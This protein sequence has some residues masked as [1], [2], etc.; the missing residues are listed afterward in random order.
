MDTNIPIPTIFLSVTFYMTPV[1]VTIQ[2]QPTYLINYPDPLI[3]LAPVTIRADPTPTASSCTGDKCRKH[4]CILFGCDGSYSLFSCNSSCG[5]Y[6]Y[7]SGCSIIGCIVNCLLRSCGGL[8]CLLPGSCGNIQGSNSSNSSNKYDSPAIVLVCTYL[9][10]S[11]STWYLA[12]FLTIIETNCVTS[13]ACNRQDIVVI[14]IPGS[15]QCSVDPNILKILSVKQAADQTIINREQIPLKTLIVIQTITII[16]TLTIIVTVVVLLSATANSRTILFFYIFKVYNIKGWSTDGSKKLKGKEKGCS[17]LT[18]W[19]W[20]EHTSTHL[21]YIYFNLLFLM[22]A[23]C[24]ERAIMSVGGPK[25][26]CEYQGR[27]SVLEGKQS[28]EIDS[29]AQALLLRHQL[30]KTAPLYMPESWG[31][32]NTEIFMTTI[33]ETSKSTYTT[34]IV[35]GTKEASIT[36]TLMSTTISMIISAT[37][38]NPLNPSTDSLCGATNSGQTCLSLSFGDCC[39]GSSYYRDTAEY[40]GTECQPEFGT[41]SPS[42]G[43]LVLTDGLC[44]QMS[45][46]VGAG[47]C[48]SLNMYYRTGYQEAFGSCV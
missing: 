36:G 48:R 30:I 8:G 37:P 38:S 32:G 5:I 11:Y 41:C 7:S 1:P 44:S 6:R 19:E 26:S 21:S 33:E 9:V 43:P 42:T 29:L 3:N 22:K 46:L 40:C 25:L 45:N 24:V 35:L 28:I 2:P 23:G 34:E 4:N 39:S 27:T 13:M 31:P 10:T 47:Y 17:T 12:L 14:I 15:L 20:D 18:G 16:N